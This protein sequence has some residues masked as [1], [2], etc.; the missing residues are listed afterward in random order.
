MK[1]RLSIFLNRFES[2][3]RAWQWYFRALCKIPKRLDNWNGCLWD[4]SFR[5]VL[6]GYPAQHEDQPRVANNTWDRWLNSLRH[7]SEASWVVGATFRK[8]WW[9]LYWKHIIYWSIVLLWHRENTWQLK[10]ANKIRH[11]VLLNVSFS[12]LK[13]IL[14][15]IIKIYFVTASFYFHM[16]QKR[17]VW[18]I[19]CIM[20]QYMYFI[21]GIF[22]YEL[23]N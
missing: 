6:D 5:W 4:L 12:L 15:C 21:F 8:H 23:E 13:N 17:E 1:S 3:L 22:M 16:L 20:I 19:Y 2:L 18:G 11:F 9:N 7:R 10:F 14:I